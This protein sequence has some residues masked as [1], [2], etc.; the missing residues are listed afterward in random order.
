MRRELLSPHCF[1]LHEPGVVLLQHRYCSE[2]DSVWRVSVM[3]HTSGYMIDEEGT[4][5]TALFCNA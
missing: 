2:E 1:E 4:S 3:K 5:L